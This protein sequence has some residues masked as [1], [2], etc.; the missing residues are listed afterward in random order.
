LRRIWRTRWL[1]G[2]WWGGPPLA[3]QCGQSAP[4]LPAAPAAASPAPAGSGCPAAA[5]DAVADVKA[6]ARQ[7]AHAWVTCVE[8]VWGGGGGKGEGVVGG[9]W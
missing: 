2:W 3:R 6:A 1:A 9:R 5:A 8:E 4:P 7:V